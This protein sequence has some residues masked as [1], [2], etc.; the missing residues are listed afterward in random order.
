MVARRLENKTARV[1]SSFD[2]Q[3]SA[4]TEQYVLVSQRTGYIFDLV[5][6]I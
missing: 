4:L 3:L 1:A 5:A 2:V 6:V